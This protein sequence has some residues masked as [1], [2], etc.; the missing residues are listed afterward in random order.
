VTG[1]THRDE[2]CCFGFGIK[3]VTSTAY[4]TSKNLWT[5]R[6]WNGQLY[7][8]NKASRTAPKLHES[9]IIR[10][11]WDPSSGDVTLSVNGT[12]DGVAW[13]GIREAEIYPAVRGGR[14]SGDAWACA[15]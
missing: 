10:F 3:P 9:N 4:D 7:G 5:V 11:K 14:A 13:S 6:A 2:G 8:S 1:C 15:A 12:L